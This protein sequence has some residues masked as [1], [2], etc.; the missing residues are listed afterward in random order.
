MDINW[1]RAGLLGMSLLLALPAQADN[2]VV[3]G[4]SQLPKLNAGAL[5][6]LYTGRSTEV[7]GAPV[8]VVN[9]LPGSPVRNRF[10]S[11]YVEQDDERYVAYWTVRRFIGKGLPPKE[12]ESSA[13]II[14]FVQKTPGAIGYI[15]AADLKPG[16]NVLARQ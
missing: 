12:M 9:A 4:H 16:L 2:V 15:D 1:M 3:I 13:A 11:L 5:R 8:I 6:K 10:L 14:D 7:N